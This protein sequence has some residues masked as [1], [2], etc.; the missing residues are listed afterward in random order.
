MPDPLLPPVPE[1]GDEHIHDATAD[2][3]VALV[4][5]FMVTAALSTPEDST[6]PAVPTLVFDFVLVDLFD[7]QGPAVPLRILVE[8]SAVSSHAIV[9]G[10]VRAMGMLDEIAKRRP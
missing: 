8:H 10:M 7:P 1:P 4:R 6:L 2:E 3:N 9:A 5:S